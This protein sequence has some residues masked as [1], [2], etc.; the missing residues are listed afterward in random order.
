[1]IFLDFLAFHFVCI[2][3][4]VVWVYKIHLSLPSPFACIQIERHWQL[5]T[6]KLQS[7]SIA[8]HNIHL[9]IAQALSNNFDFFSGIRAATVICE[10]VRWTRKWQ[11]FFSPRIEIPN[12]SGREL[13]ENVCFIPSGSTGTNIVKVPSNVRR[14]RTSQSKCCFNRCT[15]VG[16]SNSGL[17]KMYAYISRCGCGATAGTLYVEK[18]RRKSAKSLGIVRSWRLYFGNNCMAQYALI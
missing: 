3:L 16:T 12:F 8:S 1:M 5:S 6:V 13:S 4:Y 18:F 11:S 7:R 17:C 14:F 10:I 15:N 2:F 9:M